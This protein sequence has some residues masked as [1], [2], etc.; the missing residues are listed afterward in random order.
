MSNFE[1]YV[2]DKNLLLK[3]INFVDSIYILD[4]IY[5]VSQVKRVGDELIFW[6]NSN[7][8]VSINLDFDYL[9]KI[10]VDYKRKYIPRIVIEVITNHTYPSPLVRS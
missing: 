7:V 3:Y 4:R 2:D 1:R 10:Y 9:Y 6:Y 5:N 8:V